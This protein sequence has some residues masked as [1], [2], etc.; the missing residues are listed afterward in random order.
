MNEEWKEEYKTLPKAGSHRLID[1]EQAS[2]VTDRPPAFPPQFLMVSGRKPYANMWVDLVPLVYV[3]RPEYWGIEVVGRLPLGIGLPSEEAH[4]GVTYDV[5]IPLYSGL[6][7]TKGIEIIGATRSE[8]IEVQHHQ[9]A[10]ECSEWDA[11]HD[12][13]P[14][15]PATLIVSG[16]CKFPD[17]RYK[18]VLRRREPQGI[19]PKDLLLE[20]IGTEERSGTELV[21]ETAL[22]VRYEE[23]TDFEYDTVTI[24]PDGAVIPVKE[25]H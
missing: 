7:G 17:D 13:M 5:T 15:G 14:G 16:A 20:L 23:Q 2:V 24:L 12:H 22:E 1:F 8:R 6:T 4:H 3:K 11:W 25:V 10:R 18:V 21:E 19:N 9:A